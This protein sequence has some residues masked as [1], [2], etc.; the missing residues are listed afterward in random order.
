LIARPMTMLPPLAIAAAL[1][2]GCGQSAADKAANDVCNAR[3]DVQHQVSS[4]KTAGSVNEVKTSL[5]AIKDDFTKIANAQ[6]K[7]SDQ[8]K[9]GVQAAND[10][11]KAQ[12]Q[13]VATEAAN[14][15]S[16]T[17]AKDQL[18]SA[19]TQLGQSYQQSLKTSCP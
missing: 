3:A 10:A 12:L 16:A 9:K 7:L 15:R 14:T 18:R 11:F 13:D 19:V 2:T 5:G 8:R 4:L 6:P 17:G 1:V